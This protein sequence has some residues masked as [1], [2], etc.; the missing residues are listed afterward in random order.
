MC[1]WVCV[2]HIRTLRRRAEAQSRTHAACR[3]RGQRGQQQSDTHAWIGGGVGAETARRRVQGVDTASPGGHTSTWKDAG[4]M[5]AAETAARGAKRLPG[6][7]QSSL[8]EVVISS[9][10]EEIRFWSLA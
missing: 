2:S 4:V 7:T 5:G 10:I 1:G 3:S 8:I 9:L 6:A